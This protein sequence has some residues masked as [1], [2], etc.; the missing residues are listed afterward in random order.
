MSDPPPSKKPK[1]SATEYQ[2]ALD[3]LE[4]MEK[5]VEDI[6]K[7][8]KIPSAFINKR[9]KVI[10]KID[11]FWKYVMI[12]AMH[13]D[14]LY[15]HIPMKYFT[16]DENKCL[17]HWE[18]FNVEWTRDDNLKVIGFRL[19]FTFIENP[20]FTNSKLVRE[21]AHPKDIPSRLSLVKVTKVKWKN[22]QDLGEGREERFKSSWPHFFKWFQSK[23]ASG[24]SDRSIA[25][26][27]SG[28]I[29]TTPYK[30]FKGGRKRVEEYGENEDTEDEED[31]DNDDGEVDDDDD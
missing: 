31:D 25:E 2:S 28:F 10:A 9:A 16:V 15:D 23:D 11:Q 4:K 6:E 18:S 21:Y 1:I 5:E 29:W 7:S 12:G 24:Y 19:V 26:G 30:Y 3:E 27:L 20:Y 14:G 8:E 22:G 17:A 13:S